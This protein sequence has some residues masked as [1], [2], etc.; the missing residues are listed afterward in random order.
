[1]AEGKQH[2]QRGRVNKKQRTGKGARK[3]AKGRV[4]KKRREI[5][6]KRRWRSQMLG[7]AADV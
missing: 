2:C 3:Y 4:K 5:I 6:W 1:M 7:K